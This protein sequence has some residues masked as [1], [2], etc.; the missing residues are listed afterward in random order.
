[1]KD[2]VI[3]ADTVADDGDGVLSRN[4]RQSGWLALTDGKQI[5]LI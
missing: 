4:G 5:M 2:G 3:M 1:M